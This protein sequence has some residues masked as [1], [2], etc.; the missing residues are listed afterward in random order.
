MNR[1]PEADFRKPVSGNRFPETG[2]RKSVSGNRF[3]ATGF[4][5][6]V[7]RNR[8]PDTGFRKTVSET[9]NRNIH[10]TLSE[11]TFQKSPKI[12]FFKNHLEN[13]IISNS[14]PESDF[15]TKVAHVHFE[16]FAPIFNWG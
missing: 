1:F 7:S 14:F 16:S 4:R 15:L 12:D 2:F 6:P 5:K 10:K 13:T 8:F 9:G 3:P 11:Q